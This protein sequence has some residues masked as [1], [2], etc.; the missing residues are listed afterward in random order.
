MK[1]FVHQVHLMT[2]CD[3]FDYWGKGTQV[4]VTSTELKPPAKLMMS[5]CSSSSGMRGCLASGF[6][7]GTEVSFKWTDQNG[8]AL[9]DV[10][11]YPT[12]TTGEKTLKFS[13]TNVNVNDNV[14]CELVHSFKKAPTLTLIPVTTQKST[15][16][17]CVIED[18]YPDNVT[19]QWKVNNNN[20]Q[21]QTYQDNKKNK[22]TGLY[23]T[24]DLY[25]VSS[26]AWDE[27]TNY[28]CEVT[29]MGQIKSEKKNFKATMAL[30]LKT[31]QRELFVHN[32]VILQAVVS[33]NERN[34]VESA[35]VSCK[36]ENE[37]I[38][39]QKDDVPSPK[40]ISEFRIIYNATVNK[41]KWFESKR[42]TC[43][44]NDKNI[45]QE[46]YFNKG[47]AKTPK[48]TLYEQNVNNTDPT[49]V[50]LVCEVT[51]P[52]L[53]DVYIMWKEDK[54]DYIEGYTSAPIRRKDSTSVIS[55]YE[56]SKEEFAKNTI[57]CAVKHTGMD[58]DKTP[59]IKSTTQNEPPEPETGFALHCNE[60][61]LEEDEFRS[62]WST[63]T[64]FIF[65]FLFSL[66]YGALLSLS[67]MKQ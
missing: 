45:K 24:Q 55:I 11:Q 23:I 64:S 62:L 28:T 35:S 44:I 36:M 12:V 14:K 58:K 66:T 29:H 3:A 48:V 15:S 61:V 30:T 18:F 41:E 22:E 54:G 7:P 34:S 53:G 57:S 39:L 16:V 37:A 6:F 63:A 31:I 65:L 10:I 4:T 42:I 5:G 1:V 40:D 43:S 19:V 17:M 46:I 67:K 27:H 32:E 56:V 49:R 51:S 9:T 8:K 20:M 26:E 21:Q 2:H 60:D 59:I 50:S 47:D 52:K 33:G 25:I 13:H 38:P